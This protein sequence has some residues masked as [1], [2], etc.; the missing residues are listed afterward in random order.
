MEWPRLDAYDDD[1]FLYGDVDR[2]P[3][4]LRR[5]CA[6]Y[7]LRA[8]I[9]GELAPDPLRSAPAQDL[10]Q[11]DDVTQD[12][13]TVSG[14]IKSITQRIEGAVTDSR[15][16]VTAGELQSIM[17]TRSNGSSLVSGFNIPEYPEADLWME[18]LLRPANN[19]QIVRG[20]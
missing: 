19:R 6:E 10:S 1:D 14:L 2:I 4:Q 7:A 12:A 13:G 18:E 3:R 8:F 15:T 17:R 9:Y 16:F 5:A 11:V 20:G